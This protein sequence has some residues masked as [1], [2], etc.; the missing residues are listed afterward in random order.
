MRKIILLSRKVAKF[1]ERYDEKLDKD[2]NL[3]KK[4]RLLP[5]FVGNVVDPKEVKPKNF[6]A[7]DLNLGR[8]LNPE[9]MHKL[10]QMLSKSKPVSPIWNEAAQSGSA[11]S[12]SKINQMYFPRMAA[13][14]AP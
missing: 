11:A 5:L 12:K 8:Q 6:D 7:D 14:S 13:S 3:Q 1:H 4:A 9:Q 2:S 10:K